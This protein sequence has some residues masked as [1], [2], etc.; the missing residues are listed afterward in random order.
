MHLRFLGFYE[1]A[2]PDSPSQP[3]LALLKDMYSLI[4]SKPLK[5][6]STAKSEGALVVGNSPQQLSSNFLIS[7]STYSMPTLLNRLIASTDS[8]DPSISKIG[9]RLTTGI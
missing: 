1:Y 2:L 9:L 7:Y 5:I 8:S 6:P 3:L 4:F